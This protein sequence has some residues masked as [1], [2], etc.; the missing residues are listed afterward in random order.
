MLAMYRLS[1]RSMLLYIISPYAGDIQ[2]NIAFA[3]RCCSMII[4]QGYAPIAV[5]MLYFPDPE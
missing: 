2:A 4:W 1:Q 3:I 5:H